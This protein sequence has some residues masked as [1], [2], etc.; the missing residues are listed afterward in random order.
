MQDNEKPHSIEAM[1]KIAK[2]LLFGV[3]CDASD[4][5]LQEVK[6]YAEYIKFKHSKD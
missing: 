6:E 4:E 2:I 5:M 3:D 1:E